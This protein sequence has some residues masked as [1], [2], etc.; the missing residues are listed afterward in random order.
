MI[1]RNSCIG[2]KSMILNFM[3]VVIIVRLFKTNKLSFVIFDF[4]SF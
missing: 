3:L 4:A 1:M 2:L